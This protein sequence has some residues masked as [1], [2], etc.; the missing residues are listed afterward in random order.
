MYTAVWRS[1]LI[2][3]LQYYKLNNEPAV[4]DVAGDIAREHRVVDNIV[5]SSVAMKSVMG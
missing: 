5:V 3:I 2:T 1:L 4:K